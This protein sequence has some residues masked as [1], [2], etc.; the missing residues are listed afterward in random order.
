MRM[1]QLA[2]PTVVVLLGST[3]AAPA[4]PC[5]ADIDAMQRRVDARIEA[6]ARAGPPAAESQAARLDDQPTREWLAAAEGRIGDGAKMDAAVAA[7]AR[8]RDAD[9][10]GDKGA[11]EQALTEV[12][13][14]LGP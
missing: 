13:R 14:I 5:T 12:T 9:R 10:S 3:L 1:H 8:A 11:C 4:G 6:T 7:L 2:L